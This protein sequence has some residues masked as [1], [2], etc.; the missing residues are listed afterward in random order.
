MLITTGG[1]DD[2]VYP[3]HS[4]K[5]AAELQYRQQ[6]AA[7]VLFKEKEGA[8]NAEALSVTRQIRSSADW[9]SFV[10]FH[11]RQVVVYEVK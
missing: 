9:L 11:L 4:Y 7:P 8:G 10:Y 1:H 6:N 3:A 2:R 5:F